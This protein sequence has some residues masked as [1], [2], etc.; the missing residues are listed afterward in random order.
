MDFNSV[1][2]DN[3]NLSYKDA[4][5]SSTHA[6]VHS[7]MPST[8]VIQSWMVA[9]LAEAVQVNPDDLDFQVPFTSYGLESIVVFSLTGDLAEWLGR[10]LPATLLWEYPTIELLAA[11]LNEE[12][13][14]R[15]LS[16]MA[17]FSPGDVAEGRL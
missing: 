14:T 9:R 10:D 4:G 16:P 17:H 8:E 7:Q 12:L 6:L 1:S 11:H 3:H 15:S 5:H 2:Q 13:S